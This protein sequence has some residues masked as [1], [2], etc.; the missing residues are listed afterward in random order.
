MPLYIDSDQEEQIQEVESIYIY[1]KL[2]KI[3]HPNIVRVY[4]VGKLQPSD[5]NYKQIFDMLVSEVQHAPLTFDADGDPIELDEC[6]SPRVYIT[7]LIT[8]YIEGYDLVNR[9]LNPIQT[10]ELTTD[11]FSAL[12][13]LG[14]NEILHNDIDMQNVFYDIRNHCYKLIDFDNASHGY[15]NEVESSDLRSVNELIKKCLLYNNK[16]YTSKRVGNYTKDILLD[17]SAISR[18]SNFC[19]EQDEFS[20]DF[21]KC[22]TELSRLFGFKAIGVDARTWSDRNM[23]RWTVDNRQVML[24]VHYWTYF[25]IREKKRHR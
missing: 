6:F 17:N 1:I 24:I 12:K 10:L 22:V 7:Y 4:E 21:D 20:S 23:D 11:L 16:N 2:K 13:V 18:Y 15:G 25:T 19:T 3:Q 8:E 9:Q 14:S 5:L